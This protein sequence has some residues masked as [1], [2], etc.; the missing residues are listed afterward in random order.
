[1]MGGL[2]TWDSDGL[3]WVRG[4]GNEGFFTC[5]D[6]DVNDDDDMTMTMRSLLQQTEEDEVD[7][8][9]INFFDHIDQLSR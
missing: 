2:V 4:F 3:W 6:D 1:M 7:D 8:D 5:Y 9:H